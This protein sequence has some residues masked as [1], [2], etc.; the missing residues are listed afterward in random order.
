MRRISKQTFGMVGAA[1]L[2]VVLLFGVIA[3]LR[4][5][6]LWNF[7]GRGLTFVHEFSERSHRSVQAAVRAWNDDDPSSRM[8]AEVIELRASLAALHDVEEENV[9]L[10]E[11]AD[12]PSRSEY[13]AIPAGVFSYAVTGG[14]IE[15]VVNRGARDGVVPGST[16]ITSPRVFVGIVDRVSERSSTIRVLGDPS[17]QV[18]GRLIGVD[19]GGLVRLDHAG[20]VILD[21]IGKDELVTEG[22]VIVTSGLDHVPAG[23]IIGTVRSVDPESVTLFQTI[24]LDVSHRSK[25]MWRV[26]I[27][28]P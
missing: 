4:A 2:V 27:L 20:Q 3:G 13:Q 16:V 26:M 19:V 24:R 10:R 14:A 18:T 12:L 6:S 1:L 11:I 9:F 8:A 28:V 5:I 22:V 17:V 15:V 23:L 21:L 25:S 7:P